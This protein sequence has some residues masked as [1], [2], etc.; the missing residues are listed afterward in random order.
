MAKF[1]R[2]FLVRLASSSAAHQQRQRF[3][4]AGNDMKIVI[5]LKMPTRAEKA[6]RCR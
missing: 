2:V 3:N 1:L 4:K 5:D 6:Y